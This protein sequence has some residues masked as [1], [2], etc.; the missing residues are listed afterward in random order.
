MRSKSNKTSLQIFL[1]VASLMIAGG[2][3]SQIIGVKSVADDMTRAGVGDYYRG[4]GLL[5]LIFLAL[6][7]YPKTFKTGFLLL[8]CFFGGAIATLLSHQLSPLPPAIPLTVLWIATWLRDKSV[9]L[10]K[11]EQMQLAT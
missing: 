4:L 5:K 1:V 8:C 7:L 10:S 3:I 2:A 11:S 6:Y 9:F